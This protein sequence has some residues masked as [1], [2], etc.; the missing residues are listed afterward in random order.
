MRLIGKVAIVTGGSRGI[1]YSIV[2]E[3]LNE[4]AKVALCGS[5]IES[6]TKAVDKLKEKFSDKNIIP[7]GVD[8]TNTD[9][10]E[11]MV[12]TVVNEFGIIDILVN[13]AGITTNTML[14]DLT[15]EEFDNVIDIN[16]KAPVFTS[17]YCAK[18]M[19][20]NKKG[21]I[22]NTSSL[23]GTYGG[24][25]Q[26]AYAASKFAINGVTKS[27]AKELGPQGI[28]VNAVAPG[29]VLTDMVS[30]NVTEEMMN[31]LKMGTP[32]GRAG[33]PEELSKIYVYLAS[34]ESSFVTGS[35]IA[36]DGG[37]VM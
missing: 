8:L 16:V 6:A 21:V 3:F 24:R 14:Q 10:I 37:L 13:N 33:K 28:R 22:I 30:K 26:T 12:A 5:T 29:V 23:I 34:E 32:L 7:I 2:E 20:K 15:E 11:K 19:A 31:M 36:V 25:A 17:K 27:L 1:G 4:G 9:D 18:V 35:I